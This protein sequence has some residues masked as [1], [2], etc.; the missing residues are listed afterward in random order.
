MPDTWVVANYG[1][2]VSSYEDYC[3]MGARVEVINGNIYAME[4]HSTNHQ[5]I[6]LKM[7]MQLAD[8]LEDKKWRVFVAPMDVKFPAKRVSRRG[9]ESDF[10]VVQ[11]DV[12]IVC[13]ESKVGDAFIAG[14]PDFV[15]EV[16]SPSSTI[17][18]FLPKYNKY[19]ASGVKEYWVIDVEA[20]EFTIIVF[21]GGGKFKMERVEA[22][23]KV[24]LRTLE[25]LFVDFDQVFKRVK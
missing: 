24:F 19:E 13:D 3:A 16:L 11:P 25:E 18:S 12:F 10:T 17:K 2:V 7:G 20:R 14:V 1:W 6:T 22:R 4:S 21:F 5:E 23:G 15:V 9:A 8:Q